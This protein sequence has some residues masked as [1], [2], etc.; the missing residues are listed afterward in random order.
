M[1]PD[2]SSLREFIASLSEDHRTALRAEVAEATP[3]RCLFSRDTAEAR[4]LV[5]LRLIGHTRVR[6]KAAICIREAVGL[7]LDDELALVREAL[8]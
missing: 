6:S 8:R 4:A 7:L 3:A 1:V 5:R 2:V